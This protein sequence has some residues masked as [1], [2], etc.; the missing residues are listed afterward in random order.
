V[1]E[2]FLVIL[3]LTP[4]LQF[5]AAKNTQIF[6]AGEFFYVSRQRVELF[7][8]DDLEFLERSEVTQVLWEACAAITI[9]LKALQITWWS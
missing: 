1:R 6:E 8:A 9:Y 4:L 7:A 5:W 3:L 2:H